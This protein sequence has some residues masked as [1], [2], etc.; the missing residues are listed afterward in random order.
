MAL[1]A[2]ANP[3]AAGLHMCRCALT[4]PPHTHTHRHHHRHDLCALLIVLFVCRCLL[5]LRLLLVCWP[6]RKVK[7]LSGHRSRHWSWKPTNETR[8]SSRRQRQQHAQQEQQH[9]DEVA[10]DQGSSRCT[11]S[12]AEVQGA[13]SSLSRDRSL[14]F[15][16]MSIS[17]HV[18]LCCSSRRLFVGAIISISPL[19]CLIVALCLL[20]LRT[21]HLCEGRL[22]QL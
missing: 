4:I 19:Q 13:E 12:L 14:P 6:R 22:V 9:F 10:G 11:G 18:E 15:R 20:K 21:L 16:S 2:L 7:K 17:S 1:V 5:M 8:Q 3:L